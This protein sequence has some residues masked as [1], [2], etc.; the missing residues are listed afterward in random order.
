MM[1]RLML[2][3]ATVLALVAPAA[4]ADLAP[5]T[6]YV[7]APVAA[8]VYSW[9]GFYLGGNA[10]GTWSHFDA[11][12][13][14]LDPPVQYF[15][16]SSAVAIAGVGAQRLSSSGF[17]GGL[18]AGYNWQAANVVVGIE[19]DFDY[20]GNKGSASTTAV[21]P[22]CAPSTFTINSAVS[23]DWLFT[24][25]PRVGLASNNWLLFVT[26]GLALTEMKG[27]FSFQDRFPL[28]AET[29]SESGAF[30][31]TK[32]GWTVGAGVEYALLNGWSVKA[33][34]LYADFGSVSTTSNNF[35]GSNIFGAFTN[36][37]QTFTHSADLH[38]NI[39]R[40]GF[41]YKFGDP[42][43]AKY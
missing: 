10:G 15:E 17:T 6:T 33:E 4:A 42:V 34:Y 37:L 40:A 12:T 31:K 21:Y 27:N 20:F 43:I 30:S 41:N 32:A 39:V 23:T 24:L 14:T 28:F 19:S 18:T 1:N 38:S 11:S 16:S 8:P 29:N 35:H 7:K 5:Q 3:A 26:G 36:P 22:C 9:S 13:T 25:R 2:A